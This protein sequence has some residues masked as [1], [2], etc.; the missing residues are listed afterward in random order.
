MPIKIESIQ[1]NSPAEKA[2]LKSGMK[3]LSIN[4]H[5]MN[6]GL[7][8]EFYAAE[9]H[10]KIEAVEEQE[11]PRYYI[12]KK[13][14]YEPLGC[15]FETYLIDKQH[16][17]KN[18]CVF[19]FVDQMPTGLRPSLYFKDDDERLSFLFGNYVTLTNLNDKEV[20]RIVEMKI[21]PINISVHTTNPD[22]R[23]QM[24]INK[25]AGDVLRYI[26]QLADAG[27]ELNTQLVLCPGINDGEE[28]RKSIEWLSQFRPAI[29]SIAAVPVGL[30]KFRDGLQELRP[31]TKDE[32][33]KQL[34]IML[35]Y[36]DR[37]AAEDGLRLIYPSDE[38]FLLS[39]VKI[40]QEDFYD[41][42]PQLE[43]GVGGC[44]LLEDE[45]TTALEELP[46]DLEIPTNTIDLA[47]GVLAAPLL[48]KLAQKAQKK[49]PQV[50]IKV[51]TI[52]NDFFGH[53]ITVAGLLTGQDII[54]QL[55]NKLNSDILLLPDVV[56]RAEEDVFLD[57]VSVDELEQE[58]NVTLE[59]IPRSGEEL[60]Y[61]LLGIEDIE[62]EDE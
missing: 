5:L 48:E 30:T 8:Y 1:K 37:F 19:C 46:K 13:H 31:Y 50:K 33:K 27:I 52:L 55:K 14:E 35:E 34:D 32:A 43:N 10:L 62:L 21:S 16:T 15:E 4:D 20:E 18:K 7:D 51:H 6:D 60:L 47:T 39:D 49:F 24:M 61:S 12:V 38:W 26:P 41:G 36:G 9:S 57:D 44:R 42:Y 25:N 22:L 59:I 53:T 17:C 58:L 54:N 45:F 2:G 40:P 11:K 23:K 56:L 28:L 3:I 29:Q